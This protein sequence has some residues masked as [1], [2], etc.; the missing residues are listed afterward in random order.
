MAALGVGPKVGICWRSM[1]NKEARAK[2][3]SDLNQWGPILKTPGVQFINLQYDRCETELSEAQDLFGTHVA[4]WNDMDLRNDQE[5]VAALIASL[6]LVIS[7]GTAV[8]EMAGAL[9]VPGWVLARNASDWTCFGQ[10][11]NPWNPNLRYCYCGKM[12]PWE[13]LIEQIAGE[14]GRVVSL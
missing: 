10:N 11:Y 1:L 2:F 14:L 6:D 3:Y 12:K 9:G 13:P 4:V 7:A 8:A 5:G